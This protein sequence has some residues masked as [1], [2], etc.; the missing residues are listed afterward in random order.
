MIPTEL[1]AE[2]YDRLVEHYRD[3]T[4]V[5][6]IMER[7]TRTN[8]RRDSTYGGKRVIRDRR[9]ARVPGTFLGTDP[10]DAA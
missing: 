10:P 6:V 1:E 9:R 8:R 7:R 3:N 5:Q 2:L 4:N